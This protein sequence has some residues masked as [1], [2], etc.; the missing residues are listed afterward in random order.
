MTEIQN[1]AQ[2][3]MALDELRKTHGW[4]ELSRALT[5]VI[6]SLEVEILTPNSKSNEVLFT[7]HDLL[8]V[9]REAFLKFRDLPEAKLKMFLAEIESAKEQKLDI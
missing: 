5:D 7:Y 8:R 9:Q 2:R 4:S 3:A 1:I 6:A